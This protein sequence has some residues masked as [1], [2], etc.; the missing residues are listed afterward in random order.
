MYLNIMVPLD[1]STV[2]EHALPHAPLYRPASE[3]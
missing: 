2:G 3:T 1:G